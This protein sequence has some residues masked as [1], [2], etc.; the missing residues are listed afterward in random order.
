MSYEANISL[1][2]PKAPLRFVIHIKWLVENRASHLG[3]LDNY[4]W[5][6]NILK[7][8]LL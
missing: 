5:W 6:S 1:Y 2:L 8:Y 3:D 7:M 4:T